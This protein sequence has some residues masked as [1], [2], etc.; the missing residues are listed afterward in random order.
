MDTFGVVSYTMMIMM[1]VKVKYGNMLNMHPPTSF[2]SISRPLTHQCFHSRDASIIVVVYIEMCD[3]MDVCLDDN[4]MRCWG[5]QQIPPD[6][7]P[8][9][10]PHL[11]F[12]C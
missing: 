1:K 12:S 5:K 8:S 4:A 6:R 3:G 11:L 10:T 7:Y 2:A 9:C